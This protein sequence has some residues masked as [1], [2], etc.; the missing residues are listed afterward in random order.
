M[1]GVYE[2]TASKYD[3]LSRC[4]CV[5]NIY[6]YNINRERCVQKM[7]GQ[8]FDDDGVALIYRYNFRY[9]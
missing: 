3:Q 2:R 4:V 7:F 6:V 1:F 9:T 5:K 8:N